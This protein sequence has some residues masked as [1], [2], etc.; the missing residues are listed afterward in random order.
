MKYKWYIIFISLCIVFVSCILYLSNSNKV[1]TSLDVLNKGE[2]NDALAALKILPNI[3]SSNEYAQDVVVKYLHNIYKDKSLPLIYAK[4][5][6]EFD[7]N[8]ALKVIE[9]M[10]ISRKYDERMM[11]IMILLFMK[12]KSSKQIAKKLD[13]IIRDNPD[14]YILG[15][16]KTILYYHGYNNKDNVP[17]LVDQIKDG[18]ISGLE[19]LDVLCCYGLNTTKESEIFKTTITE[20]LLN[21]NYNDLSSAAMVLAVSG[22]NDPIIIARIKD[23]Y[24]KTKKE[25]EQY[26]NCDSIPLYY[27]YALS[28]MD[29]RHADE[30]W[31]F[32]FWKIS[33][34]YNHTDVVFMDRMSLTLSD[35][36]K[37]IMVSL[38]NDKDPIAAKGAYYV[39]RYLF[40]DN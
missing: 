38:I 14:D 13:N 17:W 31:R 12:D 26:I 34:N 3:A 7:D 30:Y 27:A 6:A 32:I 20:C 10:K 37:K 9:N 8:F 16:I 40:Q 15:K 36:S 11:C 2:Y 29:P 24:K 23:L 5:L 18:T 25:S 39:K 28:I 35:S 4:Y 21:D 1:D 22:S 33:A 19:A